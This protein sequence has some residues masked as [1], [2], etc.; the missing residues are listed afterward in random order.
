MWHKRAER[1]NVSIRG[2]VG[3]TEGNS[4]KEAASTV[5]DSDSFVSI[6]RRDNGR[7]GGWCAHL[8]DEISQ[9]VLTFL[10]PDDDFEAFQCAAYSASVARVKVVVGD[11][12]LPV[13]SNG[14]EDNA[15]QAE[16]VEVRLKRST[17]M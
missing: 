1:L 9:S 12:D 5:I 11:A 10:Y 2:I 14:V 13:H 6:A 8:R 16:V 15:S 4:A 3:R 7:P 17:L